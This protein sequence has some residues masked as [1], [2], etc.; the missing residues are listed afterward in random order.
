MRARSS[1]VKEL[2]KGS[3]I[4]LVVRLLGIAATYL[5]T[6]MV[7]KRYGASYWGAFSLLLVVL[8][9][10][11]VF[12][13]LGLDTAFLK[14]A[15]EGIALKDFSFVKV[16]YTEVFRL[17]LLSSSLIF[18]LVFL[19]SDKLA[20]LLLKNSSFYPLLKLIIACIIPFSLLLFHAEAFRALK[21]IGLYMFFSQNGV[22]IVA[23][24]VLGVALL[25]LGKK[26]FYLP[27]LSFALGIVLLLSLALYLWRRYTSSFSSQNDRKVLYSE[28]FRVALP[29]LFSNSVAVIM[30]WVDVVMLGY[31]LNTT[32]VGVYNVALRLALVLGI[33]LMAINSIAAPKFA[34]LWGRKELKELKNLVVNT[35]KYATVFSLPIAVLLIMFPESFLSI[36]GEEFVV[37]SKILVILTAGQL[38]NAMAGS[39]GYLLQMT[40]EQKF[41]RNVVIVG[42]LLK[43]TLNFVLIQKLGILGAALANF[44][45]VVFWNL[46]FTL[47]VKYKFGFLPFYIPFL[48]GQHG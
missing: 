42:L 6:Y 48:R 10:S 1:H 8:Q 20:I 12:A 5:F 21:R 44:T 2:L 11:S 36:F 14:F 9:I 7:S 34:E 23:S 29:L 17:I 39:V 30:G 16:L 40:E 19:M 32:S 4:A 28:L 27:V 25:L 37:A 13:R 18:F 26:N 47:R 22:Y 31:F 3:G 45:V 38:V 24:I 35:S 41:H 33:V 15:S 46:A 43:I